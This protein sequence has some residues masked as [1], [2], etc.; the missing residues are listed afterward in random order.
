ME[1]DLKNAI[2]LGH[3]DGTLMGLSE[4]ELTVLVE[5]G[6]CYVCPVNDGTCDNGKH[7]GGAFLHYRP[8]MGD[9]DLDA[10]LNG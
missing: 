6:I 8:G 5:R 4:A 10:C 7:R 2:L 3:G 9:D 1:S